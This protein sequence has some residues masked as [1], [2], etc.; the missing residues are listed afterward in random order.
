MFEMRSLMIHDLQLLIKN[1]IFHQTFQ[2]S[3]VFNIC[4]LVSNFLILKCEYEI[5]MIQQEKDCSNDQTFQLG[6]FSQT[7]ISSINY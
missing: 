2:Q 5:L 7:H 1:I 3:H 6:K 4:L